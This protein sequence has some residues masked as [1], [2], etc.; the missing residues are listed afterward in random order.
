[1]TI[2]KILNDFGYLIKNKNYETNTYD[3]YYSEEKK[4]EMLKDIEKLNDNGKFKEL[5]ITG[6]NYDINGVFTVV[7]GEVSFVF[8]NLSVV[9]RL[10]NG[11][12]WDVL[13][14]E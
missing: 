10:P 8:G 12:C 2:D 14:Y 9:L 4:I 5:D 1:M 3:V 11:D 6:Y 13:E 7:V